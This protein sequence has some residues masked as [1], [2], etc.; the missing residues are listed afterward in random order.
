MQNRTRV[1]REVRPALPE[2]SPGP[3]N[4]V[5]TAERPRGDAIGSRPT[6][7][8]PP[9]FA[10]GQ[11][12]HMLGRRGKRM[13]YL[14][15]IGLTMLMLPTGSIVIDAG[16]SHAP[17]LLLV[18]KWFVFWAVGVR[19]LVA[20]LRQYLQPAFTS[21]EILG[22][23]GSDADVLVRELG[24]ANAAWGVV[25]L[26]ALL[27]PSFVLPTALG[28]GIF[29]AVAGIE[30]MRADHRGRNATI[31][32]VSDLWVAAILLGFAAISLCTGRS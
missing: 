19:L 16:T 3:A 18:G 26:A 4:I 6:P 8:M 7:R 15:L 1:A 24:G 2:F 27:M 17:W 22:I 29:Y 14:T 20:G 21:R 10:L 12:S 23:A 11:R 28:A 25:G 9:R 5:M 13:A 31:A 30:H 32:L